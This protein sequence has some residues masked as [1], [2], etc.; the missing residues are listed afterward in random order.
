[1]SEL[2]RWED[3]VGPFFEVVEGQVISGGDDTAFVDS[4]DQFDDD[5]FGSVVIDDFEL[6]NVAIGLHN[7]KELDDELRNRSD[8]DL[9]F[10]FSFGIDDCSKTIGEHVHFHHWR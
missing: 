6:S 8:E 1:M 10:S 2:S 4:A 7:F 5:L 9:L 3:A